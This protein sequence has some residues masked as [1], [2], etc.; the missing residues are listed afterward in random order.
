M[1]SALFEYKVRVLTSKILMCSTS[2]DLRERIGNPDS[3]IPL[4][5][6]SYHKP[7]FFCLNTPGSTGHFYCSFSFSFSVTIFLQVNIDKL[8]SVLSIVNS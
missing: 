5:L 4:I 8:K 3:R 1:H 7:T 2:D 6:I